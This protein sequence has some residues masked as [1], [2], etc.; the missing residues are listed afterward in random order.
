MYC[1]CRPHVGSFVSGAAPR[2]PDSGEHRIDGRRGH[3]CVTSQGDQ[4]RAR[5]QSCTSPVGVRHASREP[6]GST[7]SGWSPLSI[8]SPLQANSRDCIGH[9]TPVT[10]RFAG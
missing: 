3:H 5:V 8:D 10:Y 1:V 4:Q 7:A 2:E 6:T 9:V